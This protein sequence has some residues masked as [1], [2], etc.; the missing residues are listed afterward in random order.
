MYFKAKMYKH[1][2]WTLNRNKNIK[3]WKNMKNWKK[4]MLNMQLLPSNVQIKSEIKKL[5]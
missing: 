2:F 4:K 1:T 5:K 3:T